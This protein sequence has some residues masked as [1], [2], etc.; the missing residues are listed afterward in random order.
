MVTLREAMD[1]LFEDTLVRPNAPAT[2]GGLRLALD[3]AESENG[4]RVWATLPGVTPEDLDVSILGDTVRIAGEIKGT[5]PRDGERWL[6]RERREG[7]FER[8]FSL[9]MPI[10]ADAVNASFEHGV[11]TLEL[12]KVEAARPR[13]I[14]LT[15]DGNGQTVKVK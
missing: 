2:T 6:V 11:L 1:R 4:Y 8:T 12:P 15:A 14:K 3:V 7:R 5:A 13:Q 10:K 9:S